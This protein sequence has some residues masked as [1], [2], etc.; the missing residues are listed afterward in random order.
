MVNP[1]DKLNQKQRMLIMKQMIQSYNPYFT[2][3][4]QNENKKKV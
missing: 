1:K 2:A 3:I 4:S